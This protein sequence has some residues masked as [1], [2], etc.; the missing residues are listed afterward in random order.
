MDRSNPAGPNRKPMAEISSLD[1]DGTKPAQIRRWS[2][3][4]PPNAC[5]RCSFMIEGGTLER[6]L[7]RDRAVMVATMIV[8]TILCWVY[9][10][11][12]AG[13]MVL[14]ESMNLPKASGLDL[15]SA[16]QPAAI[17]YPARPEGWRDLWHREQDT[18]SGWQ[19]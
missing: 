3:D 12:M 4:G 14:A 9:M 5:Y 1:G 16:S 11:Q 6:V 18:G 2:L 15:M 13:D 10:V 19:T 8:I 17:C 7:K